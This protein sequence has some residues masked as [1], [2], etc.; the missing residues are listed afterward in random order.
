[1]HPFNGGSLA[2]STMR[3]VK[4]PFRNGSFLAASLRYFNSLIIH[5]PGKN[6]FETFSMRE[7]LRGMM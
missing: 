2:K 1:M 5:A 7:N 6:L 3:S 4:H